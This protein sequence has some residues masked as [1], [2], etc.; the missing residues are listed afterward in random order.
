MHPVFMAIV[1][2]MGATATTT[3]LQSGTAGIN[4]LPW[5][6][7]F[8]D[9]CRPTQFGITASKLGMYTGDNRYE[10]SIVDTAGYNVMTLAYSTTSEGDFGRARKNDVLLAMAFPSVQ[11]INNKTIQGGA[12]RDFIETWLSGEVNVESDLPAFP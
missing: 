9:E 2:D 8:E 4:T 7:K 10:S 3:L 11:A 6:R 12:V 1:D 5:M